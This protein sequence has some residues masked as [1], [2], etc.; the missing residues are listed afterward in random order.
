MMPSRDDMR[1]RRS[2]ALHVRSG[3]ATIAVAVVAA[4]LLGACGGNTPTAMPTPRNTATLRATN[5]A[6]P[7]LALPATPTLPPAPTP[8]PATAT[9]AA[10]SP[11]VRLT[12]APALSPTPGR[13]AAIRGLPGVERPRVEQLPL[14]PRYEIKEVAVS[15]RLNL[16]V[17]IPRQISYRLQPIGIVPA[18]KRP[19]YAVAP[20]GRYLL[21]YEGTFGACCNAAGIKPA[22]LSMVIITLNDG[23]PVIRIPLFSKDYPKSLTAFAELPETQAGLPGMADPAVRAESIFRAINAGALLH[24]WSADSR[25]V[26]FASQSQ[27]PVTGLY[28]LDILAKAVTKISDVPLALQGFTFSPDGRWLLASGSNNIDDGAG[29]TFQAIRRD[30]GQRV[31]LGAGWTRVLGWLSNTSGMLTSSVVGEPTS[32]PA[33][34][35][36]ERGRL[37]VLW[38]GAVRNL[39][40]QPAA[41]IA[42]MC[43]LDD[44][45]APAD[46]VLVQATGTLTQVVGTCP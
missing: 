18:L 35:D 1:L 24:V 19:V 33:L 13:F 45:G 10:A 26:F 37:T 2:A 23:K 42:L 20:N 34:F 3:T 30:N 31:D 36:L 41:G 16:M 44:G 43:T 21:Y 29:L 5:T 22:T 4:F 46:D 9:S 15:G 12:P 17:S 40:F 28:Q 32:A 11:R 27:G 8:A 6:L 38:P 25:F 7:P 14:A 39:V